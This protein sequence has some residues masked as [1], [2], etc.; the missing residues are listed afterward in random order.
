[1]LS[2]SHARGHRIFVAFV[3]RQDE[4]PSPLLICLKCGCWAE[5]G[6][7]KG[8]LGECGR[9]SRHASDAIARAKRGLYPKAGKAARG[10]VV[11]DLVP[12]T[13]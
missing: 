7:S 3:E 13:V 1:M 11:A 10:G 6:V 5:T 2:G 12:A 9:P 8:L 4:I